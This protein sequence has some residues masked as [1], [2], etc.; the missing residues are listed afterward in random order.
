MRRNLN[1]VARSFSALRS[2]FFAMHG[3][4][5]GLREKTSDLARE[6]MFVRYAKSLW[7]YRFSDVRHYL[8]NIRLCFCEIPQRFSVVCCGVNDEGWGSK[9]SGLSTARICIVKISNL[10]LKFGLLQTVCVLGHCEA[11]DA[12]LYV[13]VH[14]CLQIINGIVYAM[15]G[16]ASLRIVVGADFCGAVAR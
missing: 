13:A 10:S 15:V 7:G 1:L 2:K 9:K 14:K 12:F 4:V 8:N 11:V 6:T 16:D 3:M 5:F